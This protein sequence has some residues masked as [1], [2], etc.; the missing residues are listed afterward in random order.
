MK[1]ENIDVTVLGINLLIHALISVSQVKI[2]Q[3]FQRKI[4]NHFLPINFN[5]CFRCSKEQSH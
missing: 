2:N 1:E 3:N 4:V 5:I